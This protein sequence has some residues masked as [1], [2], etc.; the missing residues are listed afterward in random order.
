[1]D[2][3]QNSKKNLA[4]LWKHSSLK[5]TFWKAGALSSDR[6]PDM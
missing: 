5:A 3:K 1:M 2:S 4:S 6:V